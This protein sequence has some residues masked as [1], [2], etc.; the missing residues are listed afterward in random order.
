MRVH[1]SLIGRSTELG[2]FSA[3]VACPS[4]RLRILSIAPGELVK[5]LAERAWLIV[6]I[7]LNAVSIVLV[8][9]IAVHWMY[10]AANVLQSITN[11]S[12]VIYQH[13]LA[14]SLDRSGRVVAVS[15]GLVALGNGLGPSLSA[16]LSGIF[17]PPFVGVCVLVLNGVALGFYCVVKLRGAKEPQTFVFSS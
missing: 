8:S 17:G 10:I 13:G 7:A 15:T 11:L 6:L 3:V 1:S 9:T 12:S 14:A 5:S 4:I 2:I 16:N